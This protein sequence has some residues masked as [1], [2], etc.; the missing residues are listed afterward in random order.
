MKKVLIA[1]GVAIALVACGGGEKR[2][3]AAGA[4][5]AAV[6]RKPLTIKGSDT[7]VILGQRLAEEYMG[8]NQ[9][10]VVQ[11]NGGGSGTGIAALPRRWRPAI[12][13]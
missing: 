13:C 11:V 5:T 8:K 7:M 1:T 4:G 2:E 3:T 10:A 12:S 9:G 6:D